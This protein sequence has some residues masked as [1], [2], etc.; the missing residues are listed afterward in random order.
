MHR[1]TSTDDNRET[2]Q[3]ILVRFDESAATNGHQLIALK[4][5][6][7]ELHKEE[8]DKLF[9][10]EVNPSSE[11]L[12]EKFRDGKIEFFIPNHIAAQVLK[13][14]KKRIQFMF[15][16]DTEFSATI[17]ARDPKDSKNNFMRYSFAW[18]TNNFPDYAQMI[19]KSETG[20]C[21]NFGL[22]LKLINQFYGYVKAIGAAPTGNFKVYPSVKDNLSPI[23]T[24]IKTDDGELM[25]LAMPCHF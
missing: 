2:L 19:P 14:T 22:C 20:S 9:E 21:Y 12:A 3:K 25:W 13:G 6:I 10:P 11:L 18:N 4:H 15:R 24:V 17:Y 1:L 16:I 23:K 8:I 5:N 7:L